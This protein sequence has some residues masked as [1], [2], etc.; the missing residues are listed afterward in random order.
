MIKEKRHIVSFQ[1]TANDLSNP[2]MQ[3]Q[4][5]HGAPG[6]LMR[7]VPRKAPKAC[8][9]ANFMSSVQHTTKVY[10]AK[11]PASQQA[12]GMT[13]GLPQDR[14]PS[15]QSQASVH[16]WLDSMDTETPAQA[17]GKGAG[18]DVQ[19]FIQSYGRGLV[20]MDG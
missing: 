6:K 15:R 9:A 14:A 4:T 17:G 19:H 8:L 12:D 20:W 18:E 10:G 11:D 2:F 16:D 3:A 5:Q 1:V 13:F 7:R